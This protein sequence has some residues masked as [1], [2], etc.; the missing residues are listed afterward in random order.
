MEFPIRRK[1]WI[2]THSSKIT[3]WINLMLDGYIQL[4]LFDYNPL[5][6]NLFLVSDTARDN[7]VTVQII[8]IGIPTRPKRTEAT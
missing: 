4:W 7:V 8:Y 5:L 6:F 3:N 2:K 1:F